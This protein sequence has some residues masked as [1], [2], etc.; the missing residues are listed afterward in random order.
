MQIV[1]LRPDLRMLVE[2]PGQAYLV[3]RDGEISLVDALAP[4]SGPAIAAAVRDWGAE[5]SA[6]RRLV[7]T[8]WHD[9]HAGSAADV[10]AWPGVRVYAHHL[11]APV[12]RGDAVGPEPVF[13]PAE[14][15]LHAQVA[16]DLPRAP[17]CRV[18]GELADGDVVPGLDAR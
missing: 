12:V 10:A 7:L 16:G 2:P 15:A 17:A 18:D 8:H 5:L 14:R 6:V 9:D 4:G 11:D 13:T 1:D 3:R